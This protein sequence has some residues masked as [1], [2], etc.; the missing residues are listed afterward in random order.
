[1]AGANSTGPSTAEELAED[2]GGFFGAFAE[3][4]AGGVSRRKRSRQAYEQELEQHR[5][6]AAEDEVIRKARAEEARKQIAAKVLARASP[7]EVQQAVKKAKKEGQQRS[8]QVEGGKTQKV[9]VS[10]RQERRRKQK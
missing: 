5:V 3:E 8:A 2:D 4:A 1:M 6:E 9:E 10:A 7:R